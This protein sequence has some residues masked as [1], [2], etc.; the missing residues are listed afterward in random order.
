MNASASSEPITEASAYLRDL[1]NESVK[2]Y[3][4]MPGCRAIMLTGSASEGL[5]DYHSDLD[6]ILFYDALPS[7][8]TIDAAMEKNGGTNRRIF[9]ERTETEFGEQ[10]TIKSVE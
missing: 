7:Q 2:V 8:A 10:Y 6:I 4:E 9:G 1:A 3:K 5:S